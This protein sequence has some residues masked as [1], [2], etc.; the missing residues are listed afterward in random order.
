MGQT[1][2]KS[3]KRSYISD[4]TYITFLRRHPQDIHIPFDNNHTRQFN[5]DQGYSKL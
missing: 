1:V 5:A 3:Y 2:A 4:S